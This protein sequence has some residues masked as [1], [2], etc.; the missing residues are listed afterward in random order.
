MKSEIKG[1]A[2]SVTWSYFLC[3]QHFTWSRQR[4]FCQYVHFQHFFVQEADNEMDIAEQN[5]S[6]T[7]SWG[8]RISE[9]VRISVE[10]TYLL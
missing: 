8:I 5:K 10:N 3:P 6:E 9:S 4:E 1:R 2:G 7:I